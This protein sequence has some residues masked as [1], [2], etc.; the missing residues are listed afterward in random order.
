MQ[1]LG[2]RT[3]YRA[4]VG[5]PLPIRSTQFG[6]YLGRL[7]GQL[8]ARQWSTKLGVSGTSPPLS[9]KASSVF[10]PSL[11][12]SIRGLSTT[13]I[14]RKDDTAGGNV[15]PDVPR[16]ET[17]DNTALEFQRTKKGEAA[18]EV[19]LS[20]RLK[21]RSTQ[22]EKGEVIRLLKL[23]AREWRTLSGMPLLVTLTRSRRCSPLHFL[24]CRN[25]HSIFH[26][27]DN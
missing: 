10:P 23:A 1:L 11:S 21:D 2:S 26:R 27:E 24:G 15:K 7:Q 13:R 17:A 14:R 16:D 9:W 3:V 22:A 5:V 19:D 25:V 4:V 18:K 12:F 6:R 8:R 20:A